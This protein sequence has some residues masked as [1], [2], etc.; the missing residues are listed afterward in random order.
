MRTRWSKLSGLFSL[1]PCNYSFSFSASSI[2]SMFNALF[3]QKFQDV[4]HNATESVLFQQWTTRYQNILFDDIDD[5][6]VVLL[7]TNT[8]HKSRPLANNHLKRANICRMVYLRR[9]RGASV[10]GRPVILNQ[11]NAVASIDV[12]Q[13]VRPVHHCSYITIHCTWVASLI[14]TSR[15]QLSVD[16]LNVN[17]RK[18]G[19]ICSIYTTRLSMRCLSACH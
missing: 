9:L 5:V 11:F 12:R 13:R 17:Q 4:N 14:H 19:A 10:F 1:Y 7:I 2:N 15:Q 16:H 8:T 18:N 6:I 3:I